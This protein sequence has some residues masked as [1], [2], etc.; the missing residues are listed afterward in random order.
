MERLLSRSLDRWVVA[1]LLTVSIADALVRYQPWRWAS[2]P[3]WFVYVNVVALI[4]NV[5]FTVAAGYLL[6]GLVLLIIV[7]AHRTW[8]RLQTST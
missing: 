3:G 8:T 6:Y 5:L 1:F 7:V 2:E 4:V